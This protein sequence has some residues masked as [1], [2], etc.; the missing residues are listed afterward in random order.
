MFS[1]F[2][3]FISSIPDFFKDAISSDDKA[4]NNWVINK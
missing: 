3:I 4:S 1:R 2:E